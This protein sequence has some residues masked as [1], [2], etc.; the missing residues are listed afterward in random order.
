MLEQAPLVAKVLAQ[1]HVLA[2][3]DTV[4]AGTI[5]LANIAEG[6]GSGGGPGDFG[7]L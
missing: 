6:V 3:I 1:W 2:T 4:V 5:L 7:V